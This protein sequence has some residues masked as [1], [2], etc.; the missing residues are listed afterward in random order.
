MGNLCSPEKKPPRE[1]VSRREA[2]P[3]GGSRAASRGGASPEAAVAASPTTSPGPVVGSLSGRGRSLSGGSPSP[4]RAP[5]SNVTKQR[6]VCVLGK[7][8]VG[9]SAI[10]V[11]YVEDRFFTYYNPTTTNTF[12]RKERYQGQEYVFS[13]FDAA[14]MDE[15]D[16]FLPQFSIGTHA[17]MVVFAVNDSH[18]FQIAASVYDKI[19]DCNV[20][21]VAVVLVGNK[22]DLKRET[23]EEEAQ[24]LA[25]SWDCPY[26]ECSAMN[27][28]Q[29]RKVFLTVLGEIIRKG[30]A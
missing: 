12:Q 14:G 22:C 9:K 24:Q 21:D 3:A 25:D 2:V 15:C 26:V 28:A 18:S 8:M 13:I 19:Q 4:E 17:Y 23:S 20:D 5:V 16:H 27:A 1:T 30:V 7:R 6:K 10:C 11:Q 29:V